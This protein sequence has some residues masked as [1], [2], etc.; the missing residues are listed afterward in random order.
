MSVKANNY[1]TGK[2]GEKLAAMY[3]QAKGYKIIQTNYRSNRFCELDIVAKNKDDI[4]VFIEVKT[5]FNDLKN[6]SFNGYDEINKL[7]I[8]IIRNKI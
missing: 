4:Y 2:L 7:K 8:K 3:L 5:R 6:I 1:L